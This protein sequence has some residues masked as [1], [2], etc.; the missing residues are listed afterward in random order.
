MYFENLPLSQVIAPSLLAFL[1]M[2]KVFC[3]C[4]AIGPSLFCSPC[5]C[6]HTP[7]S[8]PR[9]AGSLALRQM[10]LYCSLLYLFIVCSRVHVCVC[11]TIYICQTGDCW[12]LMVFFSYPVGSRFKLGSSG[13]NPE[14]SQRP[15]SVV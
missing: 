6:F 4:A 15:R 9:S 1:L 11:V 5:F 12:S 7:H 13:L 10:L 14:S 8:L 2:Q 3:W